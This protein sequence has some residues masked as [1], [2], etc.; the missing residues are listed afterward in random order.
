MEPES[1]LQC[2][3]QVATGSYTEPDESSPELPTLFP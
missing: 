2:S 3:Q 1:L